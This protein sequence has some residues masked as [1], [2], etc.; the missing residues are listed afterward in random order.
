MAREQNEVEVKE[1]L[2]VDRHAICTDY[3][4]MGDFSRFPKIEKKKTWIERNW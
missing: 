1:T 2:I 4:S 3:D